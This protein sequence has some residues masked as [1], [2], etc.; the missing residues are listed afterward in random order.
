MDKCLGVIPKSHKSLDNNKFNLFDQVDN[1]VC[2]KG[3]IILFNANLI[4]VGVISDNDH[5]RIQMKLTHPDDIETLSY[6]QNFN[7]IENKVP[8]FIKKIQK[9]FTCSIPVISDLSQQV[10]IQSA[11][12][13]DNGVKIPFLQK[14]FSYLFY[15]NTKFYDL[16]NAF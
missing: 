16:P 6:Y 3:D 12:G 10:N 7:K 1:I 13:S 14:A 2:N 4:H 11:R 5:L 9:N 8:H 15:G